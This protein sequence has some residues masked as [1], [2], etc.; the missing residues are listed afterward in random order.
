[1]SWKRKDGDSLKAALKSVLPDL[2][3]VSEA[4]EG[5]PAE[6]K[7]I[8][9]QGNIYIIENPYSRPLRT[10]PD[11]SVTSYH[12]SPRMVIKA[13]DVGRHSVIGTKKTPSERAF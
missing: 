6:Y 11:G 2:L 5:G 10:N 13:E 9:G 4:T 12:K 7:A 3:P 1:M 8:D